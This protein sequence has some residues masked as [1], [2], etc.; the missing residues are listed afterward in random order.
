[1]K[2]DFLELITPPNESI[3]INADVIVGG[4]S[5]AI[6]AISLA[7]ESLKFFFIYA[8]LFLNLL[9][10]PEPLSVCVAANHPIFCIVLLNLIP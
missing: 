7:S 1:M 10:G 4:A 5:D 8:D 3:C 6:L 9:F 2:S